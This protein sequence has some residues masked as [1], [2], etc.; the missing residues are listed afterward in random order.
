VIERHEILIASVAEGDVVTYW[1]RKRK[2]VRT[3]RVV[4]VRPR[5]HT[6]KVEHARGFNEEI[7]PADVRRV[8][9]EGPPPL[10]EAQAAALKHTLDGIDLPRFARQRREGPAR[11]SPVQGCGRSRPLAWRRLEGRSLRRPRA[12]LAPGLV[13]RDHGT[14]REGHGDDRRDRIDRCRLRQARPRGDSPRSLPAGSRAA[15]LRLRHLPID[16]PIAR[17]RLPCGLPDNRHK[18]FAFFLRRLRPRRKR[19]ASAMTPRRG[20]EDGNG[21]GGS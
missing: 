1:S 16:S 18:P 15:R 11:R 10:T 7:D 3:G 2:Q 4:L 17:P 20:A 19:K 6:L 5:K 13:H 14:G 9:R 8:E 12:G 21:S